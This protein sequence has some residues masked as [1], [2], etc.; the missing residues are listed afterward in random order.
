MRD[1]A[2]EGLGADATS[3]GHITS[4]LGCGRVRRGD[5]RACP[6]CGGCRRE[7]SVREAATGRVEP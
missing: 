1:A 2:L 6:R 7:A 3:D 5:L 4:C